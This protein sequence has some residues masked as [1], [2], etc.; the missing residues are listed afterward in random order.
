MKGTV[1]IDGREET[2]E[3][4]QD[5]ETCRFRF[6]SDNSEQIASVVRVEP[7]LYSV[8]SGGR[9]L[10]VRV[11]RNVEGT[12]VVVSGRRYAVETLDPRQWTPNSR[13][14]SVEGRTEVIAPMPGK[15][16]HVLVAEGDLVEAGQGIVV[17]EAMKMQNEMKAARS[18]RVSTLRAIEGASVN[19]GEVLA[20]IE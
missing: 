13:G 17:V 19:A 10:E 1:R 9:S 12:F 6:E 14:A 11:E 4:Q 18:G 5:G 3:W 2:L 7:D 15:V 20:A 16:V 8:L